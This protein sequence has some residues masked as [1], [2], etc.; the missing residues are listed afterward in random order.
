MTSS[1]PL[2]LLVLVWL[3]VGCVLRA[4]Q[5]VVKGSNARPTSR[6]RLGICLVVGI[7]CLT[8]FEQHKHYIGLLMNYNSFELF[9]Q[10]A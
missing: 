7:S 3:L 4:P 8:S 10:V 1:G 6:V 9:N 5:A 2:W